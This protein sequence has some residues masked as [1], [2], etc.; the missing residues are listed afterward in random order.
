MPLL[1][2]SLLI[3]MTKYDALCH[4]KKK[5]KL[6]YFLPLEKFQMP[7]TPAEIKLG[8]KILLTGFGIEADFPLLKKLIASHVAKYQKMLKDFDRISLRLKPIH[9]IEHGGKFEL[10]G[11]LFADGKVYSASAVGKNPFELAAAVLKKIDA[12]IAHHRRLHGQ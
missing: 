8:K 10:T 4:A 9:H 5:I 11:D 7:E 1:F 3:C 2:L 12:E 6:I